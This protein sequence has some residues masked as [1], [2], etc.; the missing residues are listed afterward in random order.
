M[1][2]LISMIFVTKNLAVS[3]ATY[4]K[5]VESIDGKIDKLVKKEFESGLALLEQAKHISSSYTYN[6]IL[7]AAVDRFN[8]AIIL[9][10]RDRLLLAYLGLMTCYFYLGEISVVKQI[11]DT[12]RGL[13]FN[14]SFWE[15]NGGDIEHAG[16]SLLGVAMSI[17][18]L[19]RPVPMGNSTGQDIKRDFEANVQAKEKSF[20]QLKTAILDIKFY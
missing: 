9:E 6:Q 7:L 13:N 17:A 20:N 11:Q 15:K 16:V 2:S 12:I 1:T 14:K 8:Q 18:S 19:G 10:K 3:I 5:I 4:F